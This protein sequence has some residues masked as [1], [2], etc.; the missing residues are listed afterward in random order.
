ML[1]IEEDEIG[2]MVRDF[3]ARVRDDGLLGPVFEAR[4]AGRWEPHLERMI[5]FW[6]SALRQSGRYAGN[7]RA[8]HA[9]IEGIDPLHFDRW[10]KLFRMT[11]DELFSPARAN[12]IHGRAQ[13]MAGGLMRG[14][15]NPRPGLPMTE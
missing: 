7:P 5:D 9:G 1:T 2:A 8:V 10:L 6:S 3:Y 15:V 12:V 11:L 4:L 13:A 14:L